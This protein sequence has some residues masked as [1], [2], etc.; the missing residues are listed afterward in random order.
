MILPCSSLLSNPVHEVRLPVVLLVPDR[1]SRDRG[2]LFL[3]C[4][5]RFRSA[6]VLAAL[7]V[8]DQGPCQLTDYNILEFLTA[9]LSSLVTAVRRLHRSFHNDSLQITCSYIK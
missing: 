9:A 2:W 8:L 5:L 4:S 1:K 3:L 7:F 6:V